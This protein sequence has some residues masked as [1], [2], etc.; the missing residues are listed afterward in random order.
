MWTGRFWAITQRKIIIP[1]RR[2][3]TTCPL[4]LTFQESKNLGF[5]TLEGGTENFSRDIGNKLP[6]LAQLS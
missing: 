6:L 2:F 3:E 5:L 4:H 1:Y